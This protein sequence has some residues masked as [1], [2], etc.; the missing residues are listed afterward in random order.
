MAPLKIDT[1][2]RVVDVFREPIPGLYVAGQVAGGFHSC[3]YLSG[4]HVGM[5]LIFGQA[6]AG[7][8]V[9]P[10]MTESSLSLVK[11]QS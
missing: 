2:M 10:D 4:T 6:A 8:A 11:P 3:G 1:A 5:T 7:N 9:L